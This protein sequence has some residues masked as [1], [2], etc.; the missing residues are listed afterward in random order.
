MT[1]RKE[2]ERQSWGMAEDEMAEFGV[3][4]HITRAMT[5]LERWFVIWKEKYD[6]EIF[7]E[8]GEAVP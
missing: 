6:L 2:V 3:R 1:P 7:L 4:H 5:S 8:P